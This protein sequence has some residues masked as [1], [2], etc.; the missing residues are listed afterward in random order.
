MKNNTLSFYLAKQT[1]SFLLSSI[2]VISIVAMTTTSGSAQQQE[3]APPLQEAEEKPK[4]ILFP[5][6]IPGPY[7]PGDDEI[8]RLAEQRLNQTDETV[9]TDPENPLLPEDETAQ[10]DMIEEDGSAYGT[11]SETQ[12]GLSKNI[13]Q[14]STIDDIEILL[15]ALNLPSTSPVMDQISKK[16][17]L[18]V[19]SA[20]TG[21]ALEITQPEN[22]LDENFVDEEI[23]VPQID[24]RL[25]RK[26]INLRINELI[27]RGNLMDLVHFIQNLPDDTL[28]VSQQN[29]EILMLGGDLIGACQMS[30]SARSSTA[31]EQEQEAVQQEIFWLKMTAFCRALDENNAGAEIALDLLNEQGNIDF[32]FYDLVSKLMEGPETRSRVLSSGL[33]TLDPL[34]YT[35]L[36]LLDQPIEA[37][38]IENS[39]A[40]IVSALVI[41]PNMTPENRF[42]AAVKSYLS[43]GVSSD[44]LRNIYDLQEFNAMEYNNAVRMAEF[45]DRPL[46]DVLLYQAAKQS[47][48]YDKAEILDVIWQRALENNDLPRKA[49]LNVET[50]MSIEPS[51]RLINHT[52]QITRG[53]LLAGEIDRAIQWY[54]FAR[55]SAVGGNG[56]ATRALINI[57][58]LAIIASERGEIPWSNDIL[59]LWWNGQM[60]LSPE[61]R[62]HKAALFY[63]LAEAFQYEVSQGKWAELI[64]ENKAGDAKSI[65]LGVWRELIKSVAENKPAQAITLSLIA[66]GQDGPGSLDAS[67][68]ST[69]V[70]VLRSF[71]LE[72]EARKVAIEALVANDF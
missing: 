45:D 3:Q 16:L 42:Q 55:R 30:R 20:P 6:G 40:L 10:S 33:N 13:W 69:V 12:G 64:T 37:N 5:S 60:V 2:A 18:S 8:G 25:L 39:S 52:H 26:F 58:P 48:D 44:V 71:G 9:I 59:E 50:L 34:N 72:E 23:P 65:S 14:P 70:R 43:G 47:A 57:W 54:N 17:L 11:L 28:E 21:E 67:G 27:E 31:P 32:L 36:S 66:M 24:Q 51:A 56:E 61:N 35:I 68:I 53:L 1:T 29:A 38:L 4:S 15:T 7:F 62:D 22:T 63:A 19:A 46:A 41:N 49:A